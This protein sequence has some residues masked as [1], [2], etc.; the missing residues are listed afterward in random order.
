MS[1]LHNFLRWLGRSI[2]R[3][4]VRVEVKGLERFPTAGPVL[5]VNNHVNFLDGLLTMAYFPRR[6]LVF[7]KAENLEKKSPLAFL[8]RV[9]GAI[10]VRRETLDVE[11]LRSALAALEAGKVLLIDPEGTRSHHGRLQEARPGVVFL[12]QHSGAA[13]LPVAIWGQEHL[14]RNLLRF[15]RTAV[16]IRVGQPFTLAGG[17]R[18]IRQEERGRMLCQVMYQLAALL[19][20]DY[21][22]AYAD[23][24]HA[25]D[26]ALSF[27]P[28]AT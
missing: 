21:R 3:V 19:P 10:P 12:A 18:R 7:T 13:I 27:L 11:A 22:G 25:S 2:F 24:E 28:D 6:V 15:R 16:T 20:P 5:V 23:L 17:G 1:I 14:R 4:V 9:W 26:D 8:L